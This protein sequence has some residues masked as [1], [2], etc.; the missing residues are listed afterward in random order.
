MDNIVIIAFNRTGSNAFGQGFQ[1][2]ERKYFGEIHNSNE[3]YNSNEFFNIG[4]KD[5]E[6]NF[7]CI[8]IP[9]HLSGMHQAKQ[10][11]H[12]CKLGFNKL[13]TVEKGSFKWIVKLSLEP[14]FG[15][16]QTEKDKQL[17]KNYL[18]KEVLPQY[19]C[20]Y[21][22]R[23][24]FVD[25]FTS[26]LMAYGSMIYDSNN[27]VI[28]NDKKEV[29]YNKDF[30]IKLQE[31]KKMHF[32]I[33]EH[34]KITYEYWSDYFSKKIPTY[35]YS[36]KIKDIT[37]EW[38]NVFKEYDGAGDTKF[39]KLNVG[40]IQYNVFKEQV[41]SDIKSFFRIQPATYY[42]KSMFSSIQEPN[43]F[44]PKEVKEVK[45]NYENLEKIILEEF[46]EDNPGSSKIT[47]MHIMNIDCNDITH[48]AR[49]NKDT[50]ELY[51]HPGEHNDRDFKLFMQTVDVSWFSDV[52]NIIRKKF[53][54]MGRDG[55]EKETLSFFNFL[56]PFET[57]CDGFHLSPEFSATTRADSGIEE[58][59]KEEQRRSPYIH[60]HQGLINLEA[61]PHHGTIIF[62]QWYPMC[63]F[64]D[65]S[66]DETSTWSTGEAPYRQNM[67]F[68]KGDDDNRWGEKIRHYSHS[69][70]DKKDYNKIIE[71]IYGVNDL[72]ERDDF[73]YEATYG[74]TLEKELLFDKP[75]TLISWDA[76]KFHKPKPFPRK[77]YSEFL[78][79]PDRL[80]LQYESIGDYYTRKDY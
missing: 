63:H 27:Y 5:K 24:S 58:M 73:P 60:L 42:N 56:F 64:L 36:D 18:E 31:S 50:N 45:S 61:D 41:K 55:G 30:F 74:L 14:L 57:H 11:V 13:K 80:C 21:L 17:I 15:L 39:K 7:E 46:F 8:D 49:V 54:A 38:K 22:T 37:T 70:M 47:C 62:D 9:F 12:L 51:G 69:H 68:Y 28:G 4:L 53:N 3:F 52:K 23:D 20:L 43:F 71:H 65:H 6:I 44:T 77:T 29:K 26:Q 78:Q 79:N 72:D 19:K 16:A 34:S 35:T 59:V 10:W 40:N 2:K 32:G 75:G 25:K 67:H 66:K 1:N 76:K 48:I 33:L